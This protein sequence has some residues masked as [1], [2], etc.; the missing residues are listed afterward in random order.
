VQVL[1]DPLRRARIDLR[2]VSPV[3]RMRRGLVEPAFARQVRVDGRPQRRV[4]A[5]DVLEPDG[6]S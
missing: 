3:Q 2:D 6:D 5:G 4:R 1:D